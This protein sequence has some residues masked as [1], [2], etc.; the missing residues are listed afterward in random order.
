MSNAE[1]IVLHRVLYRCEKLLD[2]FSILSP[3]QQWEISKEE[4]EDI[5]IFAQDLYEVMNSNNRT[6]GYFSFRF[7]NWFCK[8][9]HFTCNIEVVRK[10]L[11]KSIM[12][13]YK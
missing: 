10:A 8:T 12:G 2:D 7:V 6:D 9:F 4:P 11:I 3:C 13:K 5:L 1:S